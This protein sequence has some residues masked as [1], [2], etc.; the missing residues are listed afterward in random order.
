MYRVIEFFCYFDVKYSLHNFI[1][2][3]M[4]E[5]H[6]VSRVGNT[7]KFSSEIQCLVYQSLC[8]HPGIDYSQSLM[9]DFSQFPTAIA[10]M[11]S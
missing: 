2:T 11:A 5:F 9:H 10:N 4:H 8:W 1:H 3:T 7:H 6:I